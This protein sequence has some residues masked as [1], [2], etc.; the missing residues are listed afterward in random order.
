MYT[1]SPSCR[2]TKAD[3][4]CIVFIFTTV[5]QYFVLVQQAV[6]N[7]PFLQYIAAANNFLQYIAAVNNFLQYIAAVYNFLQYFAAVNNFLQYI[8]AVTIA[9]SYNLVFVFQK[10]V[11]FLKLCSDRSL[12]EDREDLKITIHIITYYKVEPAFRLGVTHKFTIQKN[13]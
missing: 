9:C 1:H 13:Q 11:S 5:L 8:A 12:A 4:F 3:L 7:C 6:V 10:N 2:I